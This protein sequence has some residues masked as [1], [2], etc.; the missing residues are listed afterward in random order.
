MA[1][2]DLELT[3]NLSCAGGIFAH[4]VEATATIDYEIERY[5]K[6]DY[7][8]TGWSLEDIR[9]PNV[10]GAVTNRDWLWPLFLQAVDEQREFVEAAIRNHAE[11][12]Y[13]LDPDRQREDRFERDLAERYFQPAANLLGV[14]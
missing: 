11:D 9:F 2:F 8:I 12:A 4:D 5:R 3:I 7:V 14:S 10:S 1:Q 13:T 6:R